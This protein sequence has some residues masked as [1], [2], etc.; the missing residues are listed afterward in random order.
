MKLRL[1]ERKNRHASLFGTFLCTKGKGC[2]AVS[3]RLPQKSVAGIGG[4]LCS[5]N[6]LLPKVINQRTV[7]TRRPFDGSKYRVAN[8]WN[9]IM[10]RQD[11]VAMV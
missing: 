11:K 3:T 4:S 8:D 5:C 6:G 10:P 9:V 1:Y 2:L 7:G